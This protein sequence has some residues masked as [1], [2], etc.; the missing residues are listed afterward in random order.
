MTQIWF[1][2]LEQTTLE[3]VLPALLEK[4]LERGWRAVVEVGST[5]RAEALDTALWTFS[6]ESFLPHAL[7]GG[8]DDALQPVLLTTGSDNPNK[9]EVRFFVDG[10]VPRGGEPYE[11]VVYIFDGHDPDSVGI[12]REAWK[13]LRADNDITYWQR[14][15]RGRWVKKA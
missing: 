10:A 1:Y 3:K 11:R 15:E 13:A 7:A 12:A 14:D 8:E 6:D 2:H 4:S 5:E 9:A